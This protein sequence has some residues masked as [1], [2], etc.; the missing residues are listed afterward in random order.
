MLSQQVPLVSAPVD[1]RA[2]ILYE[3]GFATI[4][5]CIIC[6][7]YSWINGFICLFVAVMFIA[8]FLGFDRLSQNANDELEST[9]D[10][11]EQA[12][13]IF[14]SIKTIQI[15]AVENYF[16]ERIQSI[17]ESRKIPHLWKSIYRALFHALSQSFSF[18]SN[19]LACSL[20]SYLIYIGQVSTLDLFTSKMCI[21]L[22]GWAVMFLSTAMNDLMNSRDATKKVFSLMDPNWAGRRQGE[23]PALSGSLAFK[24]VSFAYPSR[25]AHTVANDLSF[26]LK[27]GESLALVGPSGGGKSTVVALLER[28]YEPIKGLIELD[29]NPISRMSY[30]HLRSNIALVGQEPVLFRGTIRENIVMG[31]EEPSVDNVIEACRLANAASFIEQFPLGYVTVVGDKGSSLSGGQKQRIAIARALIRNPKI[32]LLDE[33]TSALDTQSEQVVRKAL[34]ATAIGRTSI[35]IAHRLDTIAN[36]GRICFIESGR[37]VESGTHEELLQAGGKYAALIREQK[38]S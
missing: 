30:R 22:V 28:F 31:M 35:T 8:S 13:E 27:T 11:A 12:V 19:F 29:S 6:F 23:E 4:V 37:I 21:V 14:E 10:S 7:F 33:A 18:F 3:N 32:I 17:L 16:I 9:D 24:N 5:L 38:L 34:E 20:G 36:C 26:R 2:S 15:L 25:P 1:Y